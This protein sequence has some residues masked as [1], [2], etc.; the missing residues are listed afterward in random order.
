MARLMKKEDKKPVVQPVGSHKINDR[1]MLVGLY[2]KRWEPYTTDQKVSADTNDRYR[3]DA[4]MGRFRKRLISKEHFA[5]LYTLYNKIKSVHFFL[6]LPWADD[7]YRILSGVAYLDYMQKIRALVTEWEQALIT[8]IIPNYPAMKADAKV[9]LGK[10]YDDS[11]YPAELKDRFKVVITV[12][13]IPDGSDFRVDVGDQEAKNIRAAIEE[14]NKTIVEA[15]MKDVWA[16]LADVIGKTSERLKAYSVNK[17]GKVEHTFRDTL[18]TNITELLDVVPALNV[19]GDATLTKFAE[20]IR[21]E[22]VAHTPDQ[23]RDTESLR[24]SVAEKADAILTK[25]QGFLA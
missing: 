22:I 24:V 3:S 1:A 12:R 16:R 19:T 9:R 10:M 5:P 2:I 23:L 20:Q 17:E 11:D 18:I 21:K 4:H 14:E 15:A 7:G 8:E 25:M 13:P 6:T